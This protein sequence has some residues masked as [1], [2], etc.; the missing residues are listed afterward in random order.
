MRARTTPRTA[1][2]LTAAAA[3]LAFL[4]GCAAP[5]PYWDTRFGNATRANLAAQ[6][7][8]PAPAASAGSAA[9][10]DGRAARA[11]YETYQRSFTQPEQ[12]AA[13]VKSR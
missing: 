4:Q 8:D 5:T 6:V 3:L 1:R 12:P 2:R 7:I 13:L 10:L 9:G 11:A